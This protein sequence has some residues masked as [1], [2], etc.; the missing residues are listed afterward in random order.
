MTRLFRLLRL[1]LLIGAAIV[2]ADSAAGQVVDPP[3]AAPAWTVT[4]APV[5]TTPLLVAPAVPR[6]W[7]RADYLLWWNK[8]G[9]L[10]APL[11][12]QGSINDSMPGALVQLGTQILYGGN[13]IDFRA[14]SGLRVESGVW[15]N[16]DR[17]LGIDS[18]FFFVG[19]RAPRFSAFSDANGNQII[20]RPVIDATSGT[21]SSYTD[22]SPGAFSGGAIVTN[23]SSLFSWDVNGAIN[24]VQTDQFRMDGLLGFRYLNLFESLRIED[25][26]SPLVDN[27]LT[28]LGQ[29]IDASSSLR[30][31]DSFRTNNNFYGGQLGTRMTWIVDRW[32]ISATGKLALGAS[33][34][35]A[36]VR[37]ATALSSSD[38][39]VTYI[40]GGVLATSANI[41][42]YERTAFAVV[43]EVGLNLG[44][45][46][47]PRWMVRVGYSF[48]YWSNVARPGNQV[49][50]VVSP[51]LV[52]TDPSYGTAGPNAPAFQLQSSSYWIQGIN[53][54]FQFDF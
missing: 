28:F 36:I 10:S 38:G 1:F 49:N 14:L 30:D 51:N 53:L 25:Q 29:P 35:R 12:T 6:F 22:S 9:P 5:P 40:P 37:G 13:G 27:S 23:T 41:G 50:R 4:N 44:Y 47:T 16:Q 21:E 32:V 11:V 31:I 2:L 42:D 15:L 26:L 34:E 52:P 18:G 45:H 43:P 39:S 17:T 7:I 19:G 46:I 48:I 3:I 24:F 54:G 8:S 20:A 33:Q